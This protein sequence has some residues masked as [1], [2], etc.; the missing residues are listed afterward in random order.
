MK[1]NKNEKKIVVVAVLG[2]ILV[3]LGFTMMQGE[4]KFN[5]STY[6]SSENSNV[7]NNLS[8]DDYEVISKVD[9]GKQVVYSVFCKR[10]FDSKDAAQLINHIKEENKSFKDNYEVYLFT[11]K[12]ASVSLKE[13]SIEE[14]S[15]SVERLVVSDSES[16]IKMIEYNKVDKEVD[17]IPKDYEILSMENIEGV[18]KIELMIEETDK[19]D[20]ALTKIKFLGQSIKELNPSKN[21]SLLNII[22]YTNED[23]SESWEYDGNN[24]DIVIK[25]Q[26]EK[27]G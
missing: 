5:Q 10:E 1:T 16:S 15:K 23:K 22:A 25:N 21:I 7:E 26:Y 2:T 14:R 3:T 20:E 8:K 13:L 19:A 9:E 24:K 17:A 12:E 18:T 6:V 27:L 4:T 11:D